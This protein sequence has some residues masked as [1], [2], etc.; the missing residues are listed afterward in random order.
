M[1]RYREIN[2]GG[3]GDV[4]NWIKDMYFMLRKATSVK[5]KKLKINKW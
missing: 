3:F 4:L 2:V 1:G 5:K